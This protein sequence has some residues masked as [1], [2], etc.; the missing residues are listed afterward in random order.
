MGRNQ[1]GYYAGKPVAIYHDDP[2]RITVYVGKLTSGDNTG[3]LFY[4]R[5]QGPGTVLNP[6]GVWVE[7]FPEEYSGRK[8]ITVGEAY[9]IA[10]ESVSDKAAPGEWRLPPDA[11]LQI[12]ETGIV[13][14]PNIE[15]ITNRE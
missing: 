7:L 12:T 5:E 9:R 15:W 1:F 4:M 3:R 13:I 10:G 14:D 8:S 6:G 2:S 11:E